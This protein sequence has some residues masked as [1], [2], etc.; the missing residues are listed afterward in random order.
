MIV[1][2]RPI[3]QP[4]SASLP[5]AR[6]EPVAA[7][8]LRKIGILDAYEMKLAGGWKGGRRSFVVPFKANPAPA[9]SLRQT[10]GGD[11][12]KGGEDPS[13]AHLGAGSIMAGFSIC[14]HE[15]CGS[16]VVMQIV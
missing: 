7:M 9:E 4:P 3:D 11:Q 2:I 10:G 1:R 16:R 13:N 6:P 8:K 5:V 14:R 12:Q 15:P